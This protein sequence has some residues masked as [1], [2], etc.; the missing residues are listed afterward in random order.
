MNYTTEDILRLVAQRRATVDE[1][2]R[3]LIN[4]DSDVFS[5]NTRE[6]YKDKKIKRNKDSSREEHEEQD[7]LEVS[8]ETYLLGET[9]SDI[10]LPVLTSSGQKAFDNVITPANISSRALSFS[11]ISV[12]HCKTKKGIKVAVT[13]Q[14]PE[15]AKYSSGLELTAELKQY[16]RF[17]ELKPY[18]GDSDSFAIHYAEILNDLKHLKKDGKNLCIGRL[19]SR[20][21]RSL[22]FA[23][24][25]MVGRLNDN[26]IL[27][28]VFL[29]YENEEYEIML[30]GQISPGQALSYHSTGIYGRL[31]MNKTVPTVATAVRKIFK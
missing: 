5:Q 27:E 22:W 11:G 21:S 25:I 18:D 13:L 2:T 7:S 29:H 1:N 19:H 6:V 16:G 12:Q 20:G 10:G 4:V 15:D 24:L 26:N 31:E 23:D 9:P 30:D 14:T 3:E 28:T 8:D 17:Y